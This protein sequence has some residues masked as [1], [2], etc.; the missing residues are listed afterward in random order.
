MGCRFPHLFLTRLIV[1][2]Y[3]LGTSPFFNIIR[4]QEKCG[5]ITPNWCCEWV[6]WK[7][8]FIFTLLADR[9]R[10]YWAVRWQFPINNASWHLRRILSNLQPFFC[11]PS[12]A[13]YESGCF[14]WVKQSFSEEISATQGTNEMRNPRYDKRFPFELLFGLFIESV[15]IAILFTSSAYE[16]SIDNLSLELLRN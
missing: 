13:D 4:S 5:P 16:T 11:V 15:A 7:R 1:L 6:D 2:D 10:S 9:L 14:S 3:F 8:F 12:F